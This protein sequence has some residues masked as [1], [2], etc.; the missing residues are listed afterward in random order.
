MWAAAQGQAT[1]FAT[2]GKVH[3]PRVGP[4]R[5]KRRRLL[6]LVAVGLSSGCLEGLP[7][8][9]GPR[10]PP[11]APAGEPR[12]TPEVPPVRITTFDFESTDDERLRV[13]GEVVNDAGSERTVTVRVRVTVGGSESVRDT[14]VTVP[15]G[16]TAPFS[17]EFDVEY[18]AF[19][20]NG[21]IDVDIL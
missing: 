12:D 11:E 8:A 20:S 19:A 3:G 4:Q 13:F 14:D 15:S 9:T 16:E 18:D 7:T 6:G 21:E 5:M 10:N 17:V 1:R 2:D